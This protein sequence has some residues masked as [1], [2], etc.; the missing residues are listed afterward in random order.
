MRGTAVSRGELA[1]RAHNR[2]V[3]ARAKKPASLNEAVSN[4]M[5]EVLANR[6]AENLL[7]VPDNL[8]RSPQSA[9]WTLQHVCGVE[10]RNRCAD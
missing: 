9:A 8:I 2:A 4:K 7:K 6:D 1:L 3:R 5:D 10:D